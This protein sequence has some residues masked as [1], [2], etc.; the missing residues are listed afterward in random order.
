[1]SRWSRDWRGSE[2]EEVREVGD[3]LPD[4]IGGEDRLDKHRRHL[5]VEGRAGREEGDRNTNQK[6]PM[7][8]LRSKKEEAFQYAPP[9]NR[10]VAY[11]VIIFR[12]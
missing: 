2:D 1:M 3:D 7:G 11:R 4:Q 6:W 10:S 9:V 12:T 8:K 5:S